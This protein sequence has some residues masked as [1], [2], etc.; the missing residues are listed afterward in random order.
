MQ[1]GD[2]TQGGHRRYISHMQ[3]FGVPEWGSTNNSH[4]WRPSE[5]IYAIIHDKSSKVLLLKLYHQRSKI[6]SKK[7]EKKIV[8]IPNGVMREIV[9]YLKF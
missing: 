7:S 4:Q 3:G 2:F 9:K 6:A 5:F 8:K 1:I